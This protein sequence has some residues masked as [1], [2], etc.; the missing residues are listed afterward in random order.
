MELKN[1]FRVSVPVERA[2][3]TLTDVEY[4]APCM[5]GAQLTEID[6]DDFKGQVKVKVG[7][8]TAQYKGSAKFLQ[9]NEEEHRVIL[10]ATGRDTRGAGNASA[11]VTAEMVADGEGT[12]ITISTDLKVTGKVAQFGRGVM[13]DVSEKLI[14]Q[15]VDSLEKK[16]SE[17]VSADKVL[18][19]EKD[20]A[21]SA[22]EERPEK[23]EGPRIIDM[24]EPEPVDLLDTAAAPMLKRFGPFVIIGLLLIL[25]SRRK[26]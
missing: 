26:R 10:E 20:D 7:P 9:K 14:G 22:P 18:A 12:K 1:E 4:I 23:P 3:A 2:W 8:I 6:G 25:F 5:P 11:E 21:D 17:E 15:F 24:P 16:L 19:E 13:A